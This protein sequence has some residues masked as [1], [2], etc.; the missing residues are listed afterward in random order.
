MTSKI[1]RR[2][3]IRNSSL[4]ALG[5][6]F[7]FRSMAGEDRLPKDF[8]AQE[9]LLN[10]G[11]NEN[12][13][14]PSQMVR[15]AIAD[16]VPYSNR[17]QFSLPSMLSFRKELAAGYGLEESNIL[18][19][20]GSSVALGLLPRYFS[21][22]NIVTAAPT[23]FILPNTAKKLG[24]KVIEIPLTEDKVHDLPAMLSS[25]DNN[26]QL[27]YVVNPA[28][29]TATIVKPAAL[30]AFC[31]EAS[32][33]AAVLVDEAY[34]DFVDTPDNESM[35]G[36]V[37]SNPNII[38]MRTF[39]KI[40]G[41]AGLRI[42]FIA[43]H[44]SMIMKLEDAYFDESQVAVSNLTMVAALASLKDEAHR[45]D[46][47]K[48]IIAARDYT[49]ETLSQ[50][51]FRCIPSHTNFFFFKLGDYKGDFAA[52]MLKKNVLVRSNTYPDGKWGRVSI[53]TMEEM[54]QFISVM[55]QTF[56]A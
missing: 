19:T 53:G 2:E 48:K 20:A 28:N 9:G 23:F 32:K 12:P 6:G 17:Y 46:C 16:M 44:P 49:F 39:S 52:D 43:A 29:P 55:K 36:L 22:G 47:R 18:V 21:K 24:I 11:S 1:N 5:L 14:G 37:S 30:K 26:T 35:L 33:K 54:K 31:I 13:Y 41:M 34:I 4:A 45:N 50:M 3:L 27:V 40:H 7:S 42:G 15:D 10:L 38:V 25:I 51:R 56:N 8:G